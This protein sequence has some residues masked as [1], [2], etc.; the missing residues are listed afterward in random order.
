MGGRYDHVLNP[1]VRVLVV[2]VIAAAC[3]LLIG[4]LLGTRQVAHFFQHLRYG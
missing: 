4:A 3:S 1:A 2:L